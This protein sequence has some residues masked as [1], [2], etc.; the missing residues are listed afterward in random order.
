MEVMNAHRN[1]KR[2]DPPTTQHVHSLLCGTAA[3]PALQV[4]PQSLVFMLSSPLTS[5]PD[6]DGSTPKMATT[7]NNNRKILGVPYSYRKPK[8]MHSTVE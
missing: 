1:K 2:A 6:R 4:P 3:W 7:G 5:L 8:M